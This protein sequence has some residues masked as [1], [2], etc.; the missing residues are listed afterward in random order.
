MKNKLIYF[1]KNDTVK[2]KII[3]VSIWTFTILSSFYF[4]LFFCNI[5]NILYLTIAP[6]Q[7]GNF[8][9]IISFLLS[10]GL[11]FRVKIARLIS[12]TITYLFLGMALAR[13][14]EKSLRLYSSEG[15]MHRF[16]GY[17]IDGTIIYPEVILHFFG[18]FFGIILVFVA[19]IYIFTNNVSLELFS[20]TKKTCIKEIKLFVSMSVIVFICSLW[21][22]KEQHSMLQTKAEKGTVIYNIKRPIK[23]PDLSKV[24]QTWL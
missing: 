8:F 18:I 10:I 2:K 17:G 24:S 13:Y 3:I 16:L 6:Q 7:L 20:I 1:T 22:L 19:I 5:E 14:I 4:Y 12:L 11:L 9:L 21:L 15:C 23:I